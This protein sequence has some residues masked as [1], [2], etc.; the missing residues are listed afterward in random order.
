[1]IDRH[2]DHGQTA[3]FIQRVKTLIGHVCQKENEP[4]MYGN[5]VVAI[6]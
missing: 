2:P 6:A 5:T 1:M 3:Q 4:E